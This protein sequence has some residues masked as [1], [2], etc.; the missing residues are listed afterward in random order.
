MHIYI[1]YVHIY[2]QT[3]SKI[4][5]MWDICSNEYNYVNKFK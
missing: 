3:Y 5:H 2:T 4:A 1:L